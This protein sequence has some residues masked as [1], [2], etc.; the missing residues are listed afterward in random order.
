MENI[1]IQGQGINKIFSV[2]MQQISILKNINFEIQDGEFVIIFGPSGSGKSTL[3]HTILGLELPTSG[4]VAFYGKDIYEGLTDDDRALFRK[5]HIG[6]IYQQPNWIKALS[7]IE[8]V[9]FPLLLLGMEKSTAL[10]RAIEMLTRVN[11]QKWAHYRP[12]ELSGGQQQRIALARALINNP[13][14]IVADEPT[15]NLDF[16]SGQMVMQLLSDLNKQQKKTI[17]M[18]THDLEYLNYATK[19][20]QILD[21][22]VVG[23]H[24]EPKKE[25]LLGKMHFKRGTVDSAT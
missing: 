20:I 4:R 16:E 10:T 19:A 14:L 2:G 8:N 12:T 23:V 3:L 18:V 5:K 22:E 1:A 11:M 7:V 21:G 15:G 25:D 13:Y 6:M 24:L 9:S 17:I